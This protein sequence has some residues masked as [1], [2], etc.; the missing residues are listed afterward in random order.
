MIGR[1]RHERSKFQAPLLE[2]AMSIG[3][4]PLSPARWPDLDP[5]V[6]AWGGSVARASRA[7]PST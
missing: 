1:R 7:W 2:R 4:R 3:E 6:T 5:I